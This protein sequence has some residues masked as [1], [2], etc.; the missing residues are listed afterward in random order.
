MNVRRLTAW[1]ES[2]DL[3]QRERKEAVVVAAVSGRKS[4]EESTGDGKPVEDRPAGGPEP[5]VNEEAIG[6][7]RSED[8]F[9]EEKEEE[10]V[11]A[12]AEELQS[13]EKPMRLRRLTI[14]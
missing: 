6:G 4:R 1:V 2:K 11:E 3:C 14:N 7:Q 13:R 10:Y 12:L 8:G 5:A 9:L